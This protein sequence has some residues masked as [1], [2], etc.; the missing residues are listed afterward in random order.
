MDMDIDI[1]ID[2]DNLASLIEKKRKV[3][4]RAHWNSLTAVIIPW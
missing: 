4:E 2:T 3:M 1:D